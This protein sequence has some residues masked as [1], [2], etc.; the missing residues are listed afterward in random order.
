MLH[1][2]LWPCLR[3]ASGL[4]LDGGASTCIPTPLEPS[5]L[6]WCAPQHD[7]PWHESYFPFYGENWTKIRV[8]L[9]ISHKYVGG[10]VLKWRNP[11]K[12]EILWEWRQPLWYQ[13]EE[14]DSDGEVTHERS[15]VILSLRASPHLG[16]VSVLLLLLHRWC[17]WVD[18]RWHGGPAYGARSVVVGEKNLMGV[19]HETRNFRCPA[20]RSIYILTIYKE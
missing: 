5:C 20:L 15:H 19:D 18:Y 17:F 2:W 1:F 6:W 9:I 10:G 7:K 14:K 4:C 13:Q 12:L 3:L 16:T 11:I 8:T